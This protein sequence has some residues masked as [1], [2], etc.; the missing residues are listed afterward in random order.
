MLKIYYDIYKTDYMFSYLL[1]Y[2][3]IIEVI[4][5]VSNV[6]EQ[7]LLPNLDKR[8]YKSFTRVSLATHLFKYLIDSCH[9]F[10]FT[11][12]KT[13]ILIYIRKD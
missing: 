13:Q 9:I 4:L 12:F 11:F 6:C 7:C 5:T 8:V 10:N 2:V 3:F 1:S